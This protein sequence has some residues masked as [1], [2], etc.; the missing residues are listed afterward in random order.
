MTG[1]AHD[2]P[3]YESEP[4]WALMVS[5]SDQLMAMCRDPAVSRDE[6]MVLG[7]PLIDRIKRAEIAVAE[8]RR[9]GGD[10]WYFED[11]PPE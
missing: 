9:A 4:E 11:V 7:R 6:R 3:P 2:L 8:R 10:M 1:S 5:L